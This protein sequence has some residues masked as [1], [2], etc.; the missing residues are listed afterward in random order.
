MGVASGLGCKEL[1]RF[2]HITYPYILILYL[3]FLAAASLLFVHLKKC[4][5]FLYI[6]CSPGSSGILH[7]QYTGISQLS[8]RRIFSLSAF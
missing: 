6:K 4:F 2:P 1:Y 8:S 5:S 7:L 3:F